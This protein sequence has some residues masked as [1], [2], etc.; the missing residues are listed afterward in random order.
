MNTKE[1]LG[2]KIKELRKRNH[3]TQEQLAEMLNLDL[4]YISK[5]E[6]GR[7][8][9]ALG[10]LE[11]IAK[12]LKVEIYELF[13]FTNEKS[14]DFKQEIIDIYDKLNKEKQYTLYRVAK[15]LLD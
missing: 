3:L 10:T 5:L 7:N 4:G 13:Q 14:S 2:L 15:D 9:P 8:F 1:L 11:K 6:V 12:A